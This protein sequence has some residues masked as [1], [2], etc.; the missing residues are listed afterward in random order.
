MNRLL[1]AMT[2]VL[3]LA[4]CSTAAPP[5][6]LNA[7]SPVDSSVGLRDTHHHNPVGKFTS[8][9]PVEPKGWKQ[10]NNDQA[11]EE[12]VPESG[13]KIEGGPE[14]P[15]G[16]LD[17]PNLPQKIPLPIEAGAP[18]DGGDFELICA[19]DKPCPVEADAKK[20]DGQ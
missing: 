1:L 16:G 10:L 15:I 14:T 2:F 20:E 3:P 8:R 12:K 7:R 5:E 18:I 6:L 13:K 19:D 4:A 9:T 11:P 17:D